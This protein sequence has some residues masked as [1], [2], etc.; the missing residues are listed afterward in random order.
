MNLT[1][2]IRDN[3]YGRKDLEKFKPCNKLISRGVKNSSSY[4]YSQHPIKLI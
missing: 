3:Y 1:R 4:Y 2:Y